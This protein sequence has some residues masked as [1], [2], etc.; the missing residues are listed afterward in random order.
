MAMLGI[1]HGCIVCCFCRNE[2][3]K[4]AERQLKYLVYNLEAACR[5][6]DEAGGT[7]LACSARLRSAFHSLQYAL[8]CLPPSHLHCLCSAPCSPYLYHSCLAFV[9]MAGLSLIWCT[10]CTRRLLFALTLSKR[11]GINAQKLITACWRQH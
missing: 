5:A 9:G 7:A 10:G 4:G 6:A 8:P 11:K 3:T 1:I 2:N